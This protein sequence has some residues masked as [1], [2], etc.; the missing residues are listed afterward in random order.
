VSDRRQPHDHVAEGLAPS[1]HGGELVGL[2]VVEPD[3]PLALGA[4]LGLG[5]DG[6][7]GSVATI[8]S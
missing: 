1:A 8:A 3:Q 6:A 7:S 4:G 2:S 5:G